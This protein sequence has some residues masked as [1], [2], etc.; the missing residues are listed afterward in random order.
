MTS[1]IVVS[2][3]R[4]N[5]APEFE[6][7]NL[8][9]L[10]KD[11]DWLGFFDRIEVWR[12]RSTASGPYE[13]LTADAWKPARLPSTGGDQPATPVAGSSVNIVG[14]KLEFVLKEKDT[15]SIVFTGVDPLTY[16]QCAV[17]ITSQ[18]A[19]R[20]HSYVDAAG[21]MVVETLEPGTGAVLRVV[22]GD[23][24]S[25]LALPLQEPD[26]TVFGKDARIPLVQGTNVYH[27]SDISGSTEFFY[28]TRFVNSSTVAV[29]EYSLP[30]GVGQV[31]GVSPQSLVSGFLDLATAD[32]K[33]LIGRSVALSLVFNGTLVDGRL[34]AGVELSQVTD[35]AGHVEFN[36]VRG[37][38]YDLAIAGVN[39]VKTITAPTDPTISSF[40][41]VDPDFSEQQ[42]Y[43][44]VRVPQ[45][46]TLLG[47]I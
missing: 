25:I 32:G 5:E 7:V 35:A 9:I 38:K 36:L 33:P 44:R 16:A 28:K 12:S 13:E 37:A 3:L 15:I 6:V 43:F 39:L 40:P 41:L 34:L 26:T 19:G 21:Q 22:V 30:F 1:T 18:S 23:A 8:E 4:N 31:L 46:P 27:F 20:L 47:N 14:K 2:P 45:I 10:V 29:S 11:A 24:T 42:D 17:Q